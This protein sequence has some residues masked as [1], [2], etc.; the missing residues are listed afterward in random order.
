MKTQARAFQKFLLVV[1][2]YFVTGKLGLLLAIPP[3]YATAVWP[4]SGIALGA[5]LLLGARYWPA[6]WLGSFI[7]NIGA[8]LGPGTTTDLWQ[9]LPPAVCIGFGAALQ[10]IVGAWLIRSV[11]GFPAALTQERQILE[12][13]ALAGPVACLV[14]A[15][16]GVTTLWLAGAVPPNALAYS[17]WTWWVGD[18]IGALIFAPLVLMWFGDESW[19]QRRLA[20]T[21]P[22]AMTFVAAV[23]IFIY[24][25]RLEWQQL[26]RR[27]DEDAVELTTAISRR[28]DLN[29]ELL[30]SVGGLFA[31]SESVQREEFH[32]FAN[33]MLAE[34]P[35]LRAL[36]WAPRVT[37]AQRD[38]FERT[39]HSDS[40]GQAHIM[41]L[42]GKDLVPVQRRPE[43][44]PVSYVE[45]HRNNLAERGFDVSSEAHRRAALEQARDTGK[46]TA[47]EPIALIQSGGD[48]RNGFILA[49]PIYDRQLPE[50]P[51]VQDRRARLAGFALA[52]LQAPQL[53]G[54]AI[55]DRPPAH[56]VH[57]EIRDS[58]AG[59]DG[60]LFRSADA[61]SADQGTWEERVGLKYT[62]S[63]DIAGRNWTFDFAPTLEYLAGQ[64]SL[65]AWLVLAAGLV[66][67]ALVGAGALVVT[68]R[69]AAIEAL[70]RER[71]AE[72][73]HAN[74][75]L[76]RA[77]RV[78]SELIATVSHELR[79]PLT[80]IRGSLGLLNGD[81]AGNLPDKARALTDIAYRN[82]G[83][84]AVLIDDILDIE[85]L[86]SGK[87][88]L[89]LQRHSLPA[90]I[91]QAVEANRGH[92]QPR[93]VT[94]S[95][96]KPLSEA[97]VDVDANR[98]LQVM[99]NLL[100]NAAKFSPPDSTVEIGVSSD[101]HHA[102]VSVKDRGPGIPEDFRA[103]IFERFSQADAPDSR[104]E[105]G[106]GLG[107]PI[108]KALIERMHG[109]IDYES[110]P[111]KGTTF[112]FELPLASTGRAV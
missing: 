78:K 40:A 83:R 6:V 52:V 47:T 25:S 100:S 76:A 46:V 4:P 80:S 74:R 58:R 61:A 1:A 66:F 3:G 55:R 11:I 110:Q 34:R 112:F 82:T 86:D 26:E 92:G 9:A 109:R 18:T 103:R 64:K 21:I 65:V 13:F 35:D 41:E 24:A 10:A 36:D 29:V 17:W 15:S 107:L 33:V 50:Q 70:V 93:N 37:D 105:G 2:A 81:V 84:L 27:F 68:G 72:L 90:L 98:L 53:V 44:F 30:R 57:M 22:L 5:L 94:F 45:P 88:S 104:A 51:T 8:T 79:T 67:T 108:S 60:V 73:A 62:T 39:L 69:T 31:A 19:K 49:L 63:L 96:L 85:K 48:L 42:V 43:Y 75:K 95:L 91:E 71:T 56:R 28:L 54:A 12:F 97:Q 59:P 106:T 87:V 102:R 23:L 101:G 20:V 77:N 7:T 16:I 32:Q 89:E 111:G 38:T 99:A 14:N